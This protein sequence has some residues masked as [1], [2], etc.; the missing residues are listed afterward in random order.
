[1]WKHNPQI[2][3]WKITDK[4]MKKLNFSDKC[5]LKQ[6]R[7]CEVFLFVCFQMLAWFLEGFFRTFGSWAFLAMVGY[8][9]VNLP[10]PG[11][12]WI[13]RKQ[14]CFMSNKGQG[15]LCPLPTCSPLSPGFLWAGRP[16]NIVSPLVDATVDILERERRGKLP[17][18]P[19]VRGYATWMADKCWF[20]R[21]AK[22]HLE[23]LMQHQYEF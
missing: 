2:K 10:G 11:R 4:N 5:T 9:L 18:T 17:V 3:K 23:R 22:V 6:P 16:R 7:D 14:S 1:M 13:N 19:L 21:G 8:W 15:G 20:Y 12:C